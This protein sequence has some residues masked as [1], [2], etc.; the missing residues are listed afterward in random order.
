MRFGPP[1]RARRPRENIVPMINVVFLLLVFFVLAAEITPPEP[2]DVAPPVSI[3]AE[4]LAADQAGTAILYLSADAQM[5]FRDARG[6]SVF[7][8][9]ARSGPHAPLII[10]ADAGLSAADLARHLRDLRAAGVESIALVARGA[11]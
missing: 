9:I 11:P 7:D 8:E 6:P 1:P 4:E 2:F 10:R 5:A 3:T